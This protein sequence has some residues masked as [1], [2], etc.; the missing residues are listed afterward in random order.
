MAGEGGT[1]A[2]MLASLPHCDRVPAQS[3]HHSELPGS[4]EPTQHWGK[5]HCP[6]GTGGM[7]LTKD[8][9][10]DADL[11]V[12][13]ATFIRDHA[14]VHPR[15]LPGHGVKGDAS[16]GEGDSVLKGSCGERNQRRG[17]G[18]LGKLCP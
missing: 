12:G 13:G 17:A 10:L 8:N 1:P 6:V 16:V 4:A 7:A 9:E 5:Q 2:T 14:R 3:L 18:E 11:P 15:I